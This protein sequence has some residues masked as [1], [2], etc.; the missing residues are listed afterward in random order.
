MSNEETNE[1]TI[2]VPENKELKKKSSIKKVVI[3]VCACLVFCAAV[4]G[5][6]A[7]TVFKPSAKKVFNSTIDRAF[8]YVIDNIDSEKN[9]YLAGNGTISYKISANNNDE[10][11]EAQDI[12]NTI[13][14]FEFAYKYQFNTKDDEGNF[15]LD[16]K[17]DDKDFI[18]LITYLQDNRMYIQLPK[19]LEKVIYETL[20]SQAEST[21]LQGYDDAD[22]IA[23]L[24]SVS[25]ALQN[26]IDEKYL[27]REVDE[28]YVN[29]K[30]KSVT[31]N[32]LVFNDESLNAMM[33]SFLTNLEKDTVFMNTAAKVFD[34]TTE[35]IK[36]VIE[37]KLLDLNNNPIKT[38]SE[39]F[40]TIYTQGLF[41]KFVGIELHDENDAV[42]IVELKTNTFDI[43]TIKDEEV[44]FNNTIEIIE[45]GNHTEINIDIAIPNTI[46]IELKL[47]HNK[48]SIKELDKEDFADA[49]YYED[50]DVDTDE[51]LESLKTNYPGFKNFYDKYSD[52]FIIAEPE[53]NEELDYGNETD[54]IYTVDVVE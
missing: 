28:I 15:K 11:E 27:T 3:G 39:V 4:I 53:Y 5:V 54:D 12:L 25:T 16:T 8:T 29:N 20:P 10:L 34:I 47:T 36:E 23:L 44:F 21:I 43:V 2:I 31:A 30:K 40:L 51:V 17:Y 24:Q 52:L 18:S 46:S 33:K 14:S 9:E 13:N 7:M 35:E 50:Y 48:E 19:V 49:I 37:D 38:E 41:D 26:S 1:K 32:N 22:I 42:R 45:E 6:L